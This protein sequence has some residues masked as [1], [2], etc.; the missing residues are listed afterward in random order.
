MRTNYPGWHSRCAA[1]AVL[2]IRMARFGFAA[3]VIVVVIAALAA[4]F[5]MRRP[6]D[7]A[8]EA[9]W[10]PWVV[11]IA[12]DGQRGDA[13]G[14]ADCAR[15]VD[16]FGIA[17]H[18]DGSI[19][20]ADGTRLRRLTREGLVTT[21]AT[22][23]AWLS[24][25]AIDEQGAVYA[26]DS[27][28]HLVRRIMPDGSTTTIAG[29]GSAG[30]RD[31][32]RQQ[33]RFNGPIGL[34]LA[35]GG[36]IVVAD[37]YNDRVRVIEPDGR[38]W[39]LAGGNEP[40]YADGIGETA[41]FDTPSGVAVDRR[42]HVFVADTGND[43]VRIVD[44]MGQVTTVGAGLQAFERPTGITTDGDG[45]VYVAEESGRIVALAPDGGVRV[46][47]GAGRGFRD[48]SGGLA[49]FRRPA[50]LATV[51][52]GR[53]V[54][55]DAGNALIRLIHARPP[56]AP[57]VPPSP[58]IAPRFDGAAFWWQPLLWPVLPLTGPHEIAGTL[59]E[60]R[61]DGAERLHAGIDVRVP[62]GTPVVAIREGVV[63]SPMA[64]AGFA[65][66]NESLRIGEVAYIHIRAGRDLRNREIDT[67]R[68]AATIDDRGNVTGIR[69]KRGAR[70]T[71]G[72]LIGSV[73]AFNHVHLNVGWPGEE[74]N[75]L[76]FRLPQYRDTVAP[77]IAAIRVVDETGQTVSAR[78]GRRVAISGRVRVVVD[79]WDQMDGNRGDRRLGLYAL[80]Y[81]VLRADGSPAAGFES[82]QDTIVFDR[83]PTDPDAPRLLFAPGSGIPFYG[84]RRT[85]FLYF[86]TSTYRDGA[87][88]DGVWDTTQLEPGDYILR[89][90]A[91]DHAGNEAMRNRD[92]AVTVA[93]PATDGPAPR[94]NQ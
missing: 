7:T 39:T 48:G 54:I 46:I 57:P 55:A 90:K 30:F 27:G 71:T 37:T 2:Y 4:T 17:A 49:Q 23:F 53:L 13:D 35:G 66:L 64:I 77:T 89:V 79:A 52:P 14:R 34:A 58:L 12:G 73:N 42:G 19:Y 86:V 59:G 11:T 91:T 70:F 44:A 56:E 50:G 75:P 3:A 68:F 1:V 62:Q 83:M 41:R 32:P 85:R 38:A 5:W 15:F 92:L 24:A 88:A 93:A 40:G 47:A 78:R 82:L 18:P 60:A 8:T 36:R 61:G 72:E 33:V 16:P 29:D 51:A 87:A 65:S 21:V 84:N 43:A 69:A 28:A 10:D 76:L 94:T 81:Q 74:H 22:S 45:V 63:T 31:G 67:T 26:A 25:I 6:A 20:I 80:G 9:T